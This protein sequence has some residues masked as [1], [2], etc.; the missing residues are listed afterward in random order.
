MSATSSGASPAPERDVHEGRRRL[1]EERTTRRNESVALSPLPRRPHA[2]RRFGAGVGAAA[3]FVIPKGWVGQ[4]NRLRQQQP[5]ATDGA[6]N[7]CPAW[8]KAGDR[9][10]AAMTTMRVG[11]SRDTERCF[12]E[13]RRGRDSNPRDGSPSAPLAGVCLRPLGHL[14]VGGGDSGLR[15]AGQAVFRAAGTG[16]MVRRAARGRKGCGTG[17]GRGAGA[18]PAQGF[19]A[20]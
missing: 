12:G 15:G 1:A 18:G 3:A 13:W 2:G 5:S 4:P 19:S 14:S 16:G 11:K 10:S 7:A 17:H 6:P 8:G 9:S 20:G